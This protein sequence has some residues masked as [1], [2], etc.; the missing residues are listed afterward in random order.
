MRFRQQAVVAGTAV[1]LLA[2]LGA[3][4]A[5]TPLRAAFF[6]V[7]PTAVGSALDGVPS[8]DS[9]CGVCHYDFNGGGA[10]NA[11]AEDVHVA[12]HSGLFESYEAAIR[13]VELLDSDG[14]GFT[15][16]VEITDLTTFSNTPTFPG[17]VTGDESLLSNVN[18]TEVAS[19]LTPAVTVPVRPST[20]GRIKALYRD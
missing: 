10:V 7:Y 13:S 4:R 14:D 11:Y 9:H 2:A 6:S 3:V 5:K 20:W 16:V 19:H 12:V 8:N 15:N 18:A 17:L 1:V